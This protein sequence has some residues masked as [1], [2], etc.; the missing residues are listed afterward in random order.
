MVR[1]SSGSSVRGKQTKKNEEFMTVAKIDYS[2]IPALSVDRLKKM[3]RLGRPLLGEAA[4][5]LIAIRLDP[6][7]LDKLRKLARQEGKGYQT[8]ISDILAE[9]V[10]KKSA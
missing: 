5:Q 8:L 6:A 9:Y 2:D 7:M 4:R 1:K 3:K 10:K